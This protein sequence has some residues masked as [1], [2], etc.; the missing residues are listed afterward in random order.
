VRA[1][2]RAA[3]ALF[4]GDVRAIDAQLFDD[5][6]VDIPN[7]EHEKSQLAGEGIALLDLLPLT[8]LVTSKREARQFLETGAVSVNGEK[9]ALA[10]RLTEK[11]LVHGK[12]I[13]LKRGKKNWHLT[14]W[15]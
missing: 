4:A 15:R 6:L 7:S 2:E 14:S 10:T 13:L 8:S 11:A 12:A 9:A 1:A 5:V 3:E